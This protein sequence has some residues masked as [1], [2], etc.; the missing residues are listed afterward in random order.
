LNDPQRILIVRLSHLGDVACGLG[1]LHALHAAYPRAQIAWAIQPEFAPLLEGVPGLERRILFERRGG[2]GAWLSIWRELRSF[3]ADLVVDAQGNLK[4][5]AITW[6]AGAPRRVGMAREHWREKMGSWVINDPAPALRNGSGNHLVQRVDG[7]I[8]HLLGPPSQAY[9]RSPKSS[10]A[11]LSSGHALLEQAFGP[12]AAP[13]LISLSR[14]G[15]L[16]SWPSEHWARLLDSLATE[17]RPCLLIHGPGEAQLAVELRAK[18]PALKQLRF[19]AQPMDLRALTGLLTAAA[20][21]GAGFL[22]VDS[23]PMHLAWTCGLPVTLL[24]GPCQ[25]ARTGPW[26]VE[27]SQHRILRAAKPPSCAPCFRRHCNRPGGNECMQAI[28]PEDVLAEL[29]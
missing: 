18:L 14:P 27:A 13:L 22:G 4:S 6:L 10:Q 1:L 9:D 11:E 15:D 16:R 8:E 19:W 28:D 20:E 29:P 12:S 17:Q 5:A 21:R 3:G 7:L 25:A 23:G 2:P 26:P 24:E